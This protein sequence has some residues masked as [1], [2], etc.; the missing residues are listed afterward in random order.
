MPPRK[1]RQGTASAVPTSSK[2]PS[3]LAA[4]GRMNSMIHKKLTRNQSR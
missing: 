4:E 1:L 3:A 2:M